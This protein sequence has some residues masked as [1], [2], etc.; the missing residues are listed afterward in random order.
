[1][2]SLFPKI[3]FV[4]SFA[5]EGGTFQPTTT[6]KTLPRGGPRTSRGHSGGSAGG[7]R[8]ASVFRGAG[9]QLGTWSRPGPFPDSGTPEMMCQVSAN[10]SAPFPR[11]TAIGPST[12]TAPNQRR[13][14]RR[15]SR[16]SWRKTLPPHPGRAGTG[17]RPRG[18]SGSHRVPGAPGR[19]HNAP[20]LSLR[21]AGES[22]SASLVDFPSLTL[23]PPEVPAPQR[24]ESVSGRFCRQ[25]SWEA[26]LAPEWPQPPSPVCVSGT[27]RA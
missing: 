27:C 3:I 9:S 22:P 14:R 13:G 26:V 19:A 16:A 2:K 24:M 17:V 4:G 25:L 12:G 23:F 20:D 10:Q 18:A 5:D 21:R 15:P 11:A 7:E 6:G 8:G 1:M